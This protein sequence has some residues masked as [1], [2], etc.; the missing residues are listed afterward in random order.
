MQERG[1]YINTINSTFSKTMNKIINLRKQ[2]RE[3]TRRLKK[4][5][6]LSIDNPA[7][8]MRGT[9]EMKAQEGR[10]GGEGRQGRVCDESQPAST[11]G[12]REMDAMSYFCLADHPATEA[13]QSIPVSLFQNSKA[14]LSPCVLPPPELFLSRW[15]LTTLTV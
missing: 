12:G 4:H 15:P 13:G 8:L 6:L 10:G 5:H 3:R 14:P 7:E 9:A 2:E 11:S 1:F